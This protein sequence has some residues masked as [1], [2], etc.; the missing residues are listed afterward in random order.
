MNIHILVMDDHDGSN[1]LWHLSSL[2]ITDSTQE[3]AIF[4]CTLKANLTASAHMVLA[5][6]KVQV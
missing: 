1:L 5:V 2:V 6:E 3:H 4:D